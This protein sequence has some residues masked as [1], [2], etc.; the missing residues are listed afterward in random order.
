MW[1]RRD[2]DKMGIRTTHRELEDFVNSNKNPDNSISDQLKIIMD[3]LSKINNSLD[4][5]KRQRIVSYQ[6]Q[7]SDNYS[8]NIVKQR[9][10]TPVFIP[11]VSTNGL[12]IQA[13]K[14]E[15]RNRK[16]NLK[17]SVSDLLDVNE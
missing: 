11:S 5:I 8:D 2:K 6:N 10:D 4:E 1:R 16:V 13:E 15:K 7:P 12:T 9:S 14:L 3:E 17:D